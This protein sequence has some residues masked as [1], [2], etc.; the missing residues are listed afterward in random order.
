MKK[1]FLRRWPVVLALAFF[2]FNFSAHAALATC[3]HIPDNN[4][5]LGFNMR[6]P[7][8][9]IG[10]S[11]TVNFYTGVWKYNGA[12]QLCNQ[13]GGTLF[14]KTAAQ[15]AWS[16][17]PLMFYSNTSANQYWFTNLNCSQF[18][19]GDT[20]QYFFL[21]TF[22]GYGGVT[23]TFLFGT[24]SGSFTTGASNT[25]A[26]SPF[27]FTITTGAPV[28]TVNGL[29]GDYTTEHLFVNEVAGDAIPITISFSPNTNVTVVEADVFSNLNRRKYVSQLYTNATYPTGVEEGMV[30][31]DGNQILAGDD[32]HFYKAYAMTSAGGGNYSLTLN[33]TN[34][35]SYRLTA[36][37][38]VA[39]NTNWIWYGLRDHCI[40]VTPTRA[41]NM[42]MYEL[43]AMNIDSQGTN[44]NDR[45]TFTDLFNGPNSRNYDAVTNRVNLQYFQNLGVNWLWF[46]PVHPVGILNRQTD[47]NGNPFSVGSPY[48]IKNYFQIN[49]LLSK[50]NTRAAAMNEFTN[51]VAAANA[52]GVNVMMD[53]PL[54]HSAWDCE[55]D[56]LGTNLFAPKNQPSDLIA[57]AQPL[58][59]SRTNEYDQRATSVAQQTVAPDRYDFGKWTDVSHI[60]AGRY[61][62]QVPNSSSSGNYLSESDWFDTSI[63]AE[64]STGTGN[65]HFDT[66]T[67]NVWR[68]YAGILLYW[69]NQTGCTNNTPA[70]LTSNLGIGGLRADFGQGLAPQC[71]EYII[72]KVRNRKW[73]FVFMTE[74]LDGGVVTY[75]SNRHFDVLNENL[76]FDL[77][78][79]ASASDY[80]TAFDARRTAYGQSLVL[81][82]NVSHDEESYS[83][84][85]AALIRYMACSAVDGAPMIFYGEEL[86][87][88]KNFGF[89][90]Y[91]IDPNF[92]KYIPHFKTFNSLQPVFA[93]ANR[94]F[95]LDQL[96]PVY[97]GVNQ[98]RQF[99][100]ALKSSNRYYLNQT[101]SET[102]Q[103]N[104]FSV[105]KY[106]TANAAPNFSDVVFA[107][108]TLDR[109]NTQS[110]NFDVN[111]TQNGSNLFGIQP[112]R[113]YNVKNISA[114]TAIDGNRRNY[115]QWGNGIA[116]SNL[117]SNGLYVS[118]NPVPS[119]NAGWTN[120]PFEAQYLKLY[121][122]TPP[123]ALA[124]APQVFGTTNSYIFGNS[125]TFTWPA[126]TDNQ[127]GISG[128]H[129]LVGTTAGGSDV[130]NFFVTGTSLTVF[131]NFVAHL[132]ATVTAVNNAGI[133]S[134]AVTGSSVALL[135]PAW[136][137]VA[138]MASK[139]FLNWSSAS[140][141]VY[142]VMSTTNLS[143]PFTSF[144][145]IITAATTTVS[146]PN[147]PTNAARYFRVQLLP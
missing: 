97:A 12:T 53:I 39:G 68:Y 40:V 119:S 44:Q 4:S 93:P 132:F 37:F 106:L 28:L 136:I 125:V 50:A 113:I 134:S 15:T 107:F 116:G 80:R 91:E 29:N 111:I 22:D 126:V 117:L 112:A 60:Y 38:K 85:Y 16:S 57:N 147:N 141:L 105:A 95:G 19:A 64:N 123:P 21:L 139:N 45:S 89:S 122:V 71:W 79:A 26:A 46:Q 77:Q 5:D 36:R 76:I 55:L 42:T 13:T 145:N 61:A 102:P 62:A 69:L 104:I 83:D 23:N 43:N 81:L 100:P 18:N 108:S 137:P 58:F 48:S 109:N 35:G 103:A 86:G 14:Y 133:E 96:W 127:G 33:A 121:D 124:T 6:N 11:T 8:S 88:S 54:A 27:S 140:G 32:T 90:Q 128:Y 30:A 59:Y 99:S 120:A 118:L 2:N 9:T 82:N 146:F 144:G 114:Y 87:I 75:R 34:C 92:N 49:P 47:G 20:V 66:V 7:E 63:G 130:T 1:I 65:G 41:R 84:P 25:A 56:A 17:K 73:D 115:W 52:A 98:A 78:S 67:Q 143:V 138:S 110:G 24:N 72:N 3:W 51:F 70:N 31:P 135:N 129:V 131:G 10:T 94:T 142:Q 74:S 101:G